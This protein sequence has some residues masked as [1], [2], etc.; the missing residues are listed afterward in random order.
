MLAR[1][2]VIVVHVAFLALY[3]KYV[4]SLRYLVLIIRGYQTLILIA[5]PAGGPYIMHERQ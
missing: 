4:C 1:K 2:C 3:A 5:A